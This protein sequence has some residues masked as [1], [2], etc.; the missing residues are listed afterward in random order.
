MLITH[1]HFGGYSTHSEQIV[2][3]LH[4]TII[5]KR[6]PLIV[7]NVVAEGINYYVEL[8]DRGDFQFQRGKVTAL[9]SQEHITPAHDNVETLLL[10]LPKVFAFGRFYSVKM[11]NNGDGV[12]SVIKAALL[13][14]LLKNAVQVNSHALN[15]K[16][17]W[18]SSS[19]I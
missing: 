9:N 2:L 8:Q 7:S 12:F 14:S 17:A 11:Q 18:V 4:A 10:E 3:L 5:I 13:S 1:A 15:I 16:R 6:G 19:V